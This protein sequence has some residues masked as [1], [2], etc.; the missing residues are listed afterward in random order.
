MLGSSES[1]STLGDGGDTDGGGAEVD[2]AAGS[3]VLGEGEGMGGCAAHDATTTTVAMAPR[4][5]R[6]IVPR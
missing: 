6:F 1:S 5:G 4:S 3:A 2:D